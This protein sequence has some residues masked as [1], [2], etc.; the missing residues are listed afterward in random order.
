[1]RADFKV[2]VDACVLANHA[3]CDV[4]LRLA[5]RPRLFLPVWSEEVLAEVRRTHVG[6]LGWPEHL[7]DHYQTEIRRAFPEA[8]IGGYEPL[9]ENLTNDPKDRHALAAAIRGECPLIL[10]FNLRQ[11]PET[12]LAHWS[13]RATHPQDYLLVLH[14]LDPGRVMGCLGEIAGRRKLEIQDVLLKLGKSVPAFS[15]TLLDDLGG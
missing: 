3:V 9:M 11:F 1:M 12:S 6:N 13:V 2:F 7:A 10:T 14:G 15:A 5:E 4:L 8:I